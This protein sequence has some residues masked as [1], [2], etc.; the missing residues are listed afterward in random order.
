MRTR[1]RQ[2]VAKARREGRRGRRLAAALLVMNAPRAMKAAP[3]RL[4]I[5]RGSLTAL[6]ATLA[7]LAL[8][9]PQTPAQPATDNARR[10]EQQRQKLEEAARE[11]G[12]ILDALERIDRSV[13]E[14]ETALE[15]LRARQEAVEKR[16]AGLEKERQDLELELA[17][18]RVQ[19]QK[20]LRAL[21][22]YSTKG[23]MQAVFGGGSGTDIL[24]RTKYLNLI[25]KRDMELLQ[26]QRRAIDRFGEVKRSLETE[27]LQVKSLTR[28]VESQVTAAQEDRLRKQAIL[29]RVQQE[30]STASQ[31][32][33]ELEAAAAALSRRVEALPVSAPVAVAS[34]PA[35]TK[36]L[37][38]PP[39]APAVPGQPGAPPPGQPT[40]A[41]QAARPPPGPEPRAISGFGAQRGR[42][43]FPVDG[44]KV[45]KAFGRYKAPGMKAFDF[46]RGVD[47]TCPAGLEI[48]AVFNGEVKLAEWF[49][50]Y[51]QLLI[52]DHGDGF[53]SIYAHA[54]KL[55]K[56]A[57]DKVKTGEKIA[58]VG[59]TGSF[60]GPYL[61]LEIRENGK[62]VN[63]LEWIRV[64]PD[65]MA[66]E[67]GE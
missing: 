11:E 6:V 30:R 29:K 22:K 64:P 18:R 50:G 33:K 56:K 4:R 48:H 27:R 36:G 26:S 46:H 44:A 12:S 42:L 15:Q 7:T 63:P 38:T 8:W 66:L 55:F 9:V 2:G 61:Y 35:T 65:A 23:F 5:A 41:A 31:T 57:G 3:A 39:P 67:G 10:L 45:T 24:K 20:R 28:D 43:P 62:P 1:D 21:Y 40:P 32:L 47:I 59:D 16:I 52:V 58:L 19:L 17:R 37:Q 60:Q 51:G 13:Q 53:H 49:K 54:S 34:A 14:K 25:V